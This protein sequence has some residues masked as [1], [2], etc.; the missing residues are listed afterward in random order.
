V[1]NLGEARL[2]VIISRSII[3]CPSKFQLSATYLKLLKPAP[4][5]P[6]NTVEVPI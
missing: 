3:K 1:K 4:E 6:G 5:I 2:S